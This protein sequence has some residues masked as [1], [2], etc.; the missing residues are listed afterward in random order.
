MTTNVLPRNVL[1]S[2]VDSIMSNTINP[3]PKS[4][5][6][7]VLEG[8][9]NLETE[10]ST[11]NCYITVRFWQACLDMV[12]TPNERNRVCAV[13]TPAAGKT[14]HH[15]STDPNASKGGAHSTLSGALHARK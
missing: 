8:V 5:G 11:S 10:V 13:G 15:F 4:N 14:P 12:N 3:T 9:V 6:M 2:F 7:R 1:E